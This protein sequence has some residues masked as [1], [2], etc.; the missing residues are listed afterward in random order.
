MSGDRDFFTAQDRPTI[1]I[2]IPTLNEARNIPLGRLPRQVARDRQAGRRRFDLPIRAAA[3]TAESD[4]TAGNHPPSAPIARPRR[5]M[6]VQ[7]GIAE[8]NTA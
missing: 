8:P 3:P 7:S 4:A 1:S 5:S 6:G 2:V